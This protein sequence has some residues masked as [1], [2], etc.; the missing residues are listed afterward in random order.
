MFPTQ[1]FS[2]THT[3]TH[4]YTHTQKQFNNGQLT[5]NGQINTTVGAINLTSVDASAGTSLLQLAI[6]QALTDGITQATNQITVATL[7]T[8][9]QTVLNGLAPFTNS[10]GSVVS[11]ITQLL[12]TVGGT[13]SAS[14]VSNIVTQLQ[15]IGAIP[16]GA[17][18]TTIT[19]IVSTIATNLCNPTTS[20]SCTQLQDSANTIQS[21]NAAAAAANPSGTPGS[22]PY[23]ELLSSPVY[24]QATKVRDMDPDNAARFKSSFFTSEGV[25]KVLPTNFRITSMDLML[26]PPQQS[27]RRR[28]SAPT[29]YTLWAQFNYTA[30]CTPSTPACDLTSTASLAAY[31]QLL[32]GVNTL[33]ASYQPISSQY[34]FAN[35]LTYNWP[36]ILTNALAFCQGLNGA[37]DS[38]DQTKDWV[39]N[40]TRCGI[41]PKLT[42]GTCLQLDPDAP[43]TADGRLQSTY[44]TCN[45]AVQTTATAAP[46]G[47]TST[48][49]PGPSNRDASTGGSSGGGSSIVPIA[50]AA[51]GGAIL[52]I[53][54][55]V[56][57]MKR[58]GK[59]AAAP[60]KRAADDRTVVAFENP[61]YDDP[62]QGGRQPVYDSAIGSGDH[63]GL[64]DEPAFA[65]SKNPLKKENPL[66][67]S[68]E[69]LDGNAIYDN[70]TGGGAGNY[71]DVNPGDQYLQTGAAN[72]GY[73]DTAP[74]D[75][76]YLDTHPNPEKG[77]GCELKFICF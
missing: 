9:I 45:A 31:T 58:R 3:H 10:P 53:I 32:S 26:K 74:A 4:T 51:G 40:I 29:E 42:N 22:T 24:T 16:S 33:A 48:T 68:H 2:F 62:T 41:L 7:P 27:A 75:P 73:L 63:E 19:N 38:A 69:N 46:S 77:G 11:N 66:Y 43:Y 15:T 70:D 60:A 56:L 64:Y 50:A 71:Q 8:T 52:V 47:T 25:F 72:P 67:S 13:C 20:S 65:A 6:K 54:I 55:I 12:N 59:R 23:I 44:R 30:F 36:L 35:N 57:L 17:D 1:N 76:A 39:V 14:C 49:A 37:A 21:N 61:M 18:P 5:F 34:F 28:R